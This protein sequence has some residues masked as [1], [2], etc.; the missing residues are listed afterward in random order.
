MRKL[1]TVRKINNLEPIEGADAIM[2][3]TIDGWRVVVKKEE[4]KINDFCVYFEIDSFLPIW[5]EFEHL[6]E[7]CFKRMGEKEGLR[8]R[9]IKLRGQ[10]S[11][12][13]ALP[14][15][16]FFKRFEGSKF[17]E[18]QE[19]SEFFFTGA[20]LSDFLNVE[21]YEVPVPVEIAGQVRGNF[22]KFIKKT[23]QERCQNLVRDIF[24]HNKDT[25]YEVSVKL[26]G[27]SFTSFYVDGEEGVCGR[28]WELDINEVNAGNALVRMYQDSGLQTVLRDFRRNL[29]VQG[30]LM[31]P[32]IQQNREGFKSTQLFVFDMYDIDGGCYITPD[33][34]HSIFK[35]LCRRKLNT[36][37]VKHVPVLHYPITLG[38]LGITDMSSLLQYSEG[39]SISNPVR[40]G[41]VFKSG[42]G[43]FTFKVIS[44][45][46]LLKNNE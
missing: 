33:E 31:G 22:P 1:A 45:K 43:K 42:D 8:L 13:L 4:F 19:L 38:S 28:N 36:D 18:G 39:P 27:T 7:R 2:V 21:K 10:V 40:E 35:E 12:G 41:L 23:D 26:D 29:A 3:A 34:R 37:M 14:V 16:L 20:D 44:N 17:D 6:K 15:H 9:T 25:E 32:G 24:V 5:P 11:Q 46:F 30:E